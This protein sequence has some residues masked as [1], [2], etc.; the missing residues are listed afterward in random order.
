MIAHLQD[1]RFEGAQIL[2]P[3]TARLMHARQFVNLPE[4]NAMA[5]GFY[6]ESRNGHRIIGHGGDLQYFHSDLHLIPDLN[7]GFFISYNS[8]GKGDSEIRESIW[9]KFL[10]RYLPYHSSDGAKL[11][12]A[13]QDVQTVSGRYLTSRRSQTTIM[14]V[15]DLFTG[16]VKVS[17]NDDGTISLNELKDFNG[18][19]KHLRETAPLL[20]RDVNGQDKVGFKRDGAGRLVLVI[21]FPAMVFQQTRPSENAGLVVPL[22]VAAVVVLA[23]TLLLWPVAALIRRHYGRVLTLT[24]KQRRLRTIVRVV[25]VLDL[26]FLLS[27]AAWFAMA[28]KDLGWLSS[29]MD[30]WLRLMQLIGWLGVVGSPALLFNL[31]Q[32]WTDHEGWLGSKLGNTAIA[33][34]GM[35]FVWYVFAWRLLAFSLKY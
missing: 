17:A 18:E 11:A 3:E 5:L 34:A 14:K 9:R 15:A 10:D 31:I 27:F 16:E 12:D 33:L 1:G 21:D 7:L 32:S 2:R 23:L 25:C 28:F 8:A 19:P 26:V 13:A 6:E 24:P 4:M 22:F 20:F 30:P 29:R 35:V